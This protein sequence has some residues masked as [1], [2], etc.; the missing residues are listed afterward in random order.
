MEVVTREDQ[1]QAPEQRMEAMEAMASESAIH[2]GRHFN[3]FILECVNMCLRIYFPIPSHSWIS[4]ILTQMWEF[5][6]ILTVSTIIAISNLIV[7]FPE[8]RR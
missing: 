4:K 7:L 6:H 3:D 8:P 2:L 1:P 5:P